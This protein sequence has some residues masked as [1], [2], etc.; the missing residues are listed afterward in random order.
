MT[1]YNNDRSFKGTFPVIYRLAFLFSVHHFQFHFHYSI[2]IN[3]LVCN[4]AV[5]LA[6]SFIEKPSRTIA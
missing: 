6:S 1:I 3:V 2:C 4:V 5:N